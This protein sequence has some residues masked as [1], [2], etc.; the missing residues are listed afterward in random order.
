VRTDYKLPFASLS[1][2]NYRLFFMGQGVSLIGTWVQRVT[3]GWFVYRITN[4]H[5]LLGLVSFLSM[6]PTLFISPFAGAFADKWN[7]HHT[8]VLT[9]TAYMIQ[10]GLLALATLTE[11]INPGRLW[12][13]L[14]LSLLM[15][16]IEAID[17]PI[18][19]TFVKDLVN[20]RT[21]LPDAIASNSA[22]FNGARLVG[23]AIGGALIIVFSEGVCFAI[24]SA[25]YL[26][27]IVS[28]LFMKID[29]PPRQAK[30]EPVLTKILEGWK[31]SWKSVPIRFLVLNLSFYT[32]FGLSYATLLP[33]FARDVL[34]GNSG[35]QGALMS[36]VGIGA[37][38][39]AL[40][41]GSRKTIK[42]LPQLL[43]FSGIIGSLS[44]IA[45]SLSTNVYLSM[46]LMLFT[47]F[48]MT[49][50]MIATNTIIQ[51]V[52]D[53]KMHGR[54]MSVYTMAFGSISPFG[55]LLIGTLSGSLGT[56][57]AV[58][59]GL[60]AAQ[61]SSLGAQIAL[62][63]CALACLI[64][65]LLSLRKIPLLVRDIVRMLIHNK[66]TEIYRQTPALGLS[67]SE[68]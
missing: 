65:S 19:Q 61:A 41:L 53:E 68:Q 67:V 46:G 36:C 59:V 40:F 22:M 25:T 35:T 32:L 55:N 29:Y 1:I 26:A 60:P 2:R 57:L 18:R 56:L 12:P 9:Q 11:Y 24:N 21:L 14:C 45:L 50:Q 52:V 20:K 23:P 13:I 63:L 39:G 43:V 34:K 16:C 8:L 7:R 64:W 42:G 58:K 30:N 49:T 3:M 38:A 31:Y 48:G 27:V 17:A 66:N 15:G 44:L 6:I 4:S 51:S 33:I 47:G 5:F 28:L 37:L 10:A 54:V 62:G